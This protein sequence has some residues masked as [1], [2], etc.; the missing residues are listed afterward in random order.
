MANPN[1]LLP[2]DKKPKKQDIIAAQKII[3]DISSGVYRS[4]AAALKELVSNA[5]DADATKVTITTDAPNFRNL[6]IEDNGTGMTIEDFLQVVTHIGGS[7][8]RMDGETSEI[9][10]RKLI[11]R[12]GIGMLAVA[13][14]GNRFYVSSTVKGSKKR[15]AAE[16][17]LEP[18]HRDDAALKNMAKIDSDGKIQIGAVRYVDDLPE[19]S[20]LQYTVITVPDA[21]KGLISEMTSAVRR[22]VGATEVLTV[23][24][25]TIKGF[26]D[27]VRIVR[28]AQRADLVLD[29]YYYMLWE[30]ALLAPL[31]YLPGGPFEQDDRKIE[32]ASKFSPPTIESFQLIVDGIELFR[33][34]L[35]PNTKAFNYS[36]PDPKLYLLDHDRMVAGRRLR[37][38]GYIYS[39]QPRVHPEEFKGV[40]IRIRHV[41]I[42]KYD[43]SW[44]GY[45]FDEGIKFGQVTGEIYVEDGLEPALNIDR[46]SFRETDVHYQAMRAYVWDL[47]RTKI[48]PEFKSRSKKFR[49]EHQAASEATIEKLFDEKLSKLSAPITG[50]IVFKTVSEP[51]LSTWIGIDGTNLIVDKSKWETFLQTNTISGDAAKRFLKLLRVLISSE[52]LSDLNPEEAENLLEALAVAVQD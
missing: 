51:T 5:Y 18:F 35:F 48:F 17:N 4:P 32:G 10:K 34:Q 46:D 40:H 43:K 15:F 28:S 37:F 16:V 44:L 9:F 31:N 45:P 29:G 27:L 6:V 50:K 12:I 14:L 41:G 3:A 26:A 42:G 22:A 11:G 47:L 23:E 49:E 38:N 13:Q 25:P 21:K 1:H 7:R 39:Q 30:L 24:K 36:S 20:D 8:K 2:P 19:S 33:P 52:V